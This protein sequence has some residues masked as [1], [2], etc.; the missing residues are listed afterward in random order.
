MCPAAT[1]PGGQVVNGWSPSSRAGRWANSGFVTEI[2]PTQLRDAG[3]D[4][5]DPF[6][7]LD[8]QRR[9][10]RAAYEAGGGSY[11][12][13]AQRLDDFVAGRDSS[14]LPRC[15]YPRG[16]VPARLDTLLGPL[17]P[18]L[19]EALRRIDARMPGFVAPHAVAV[20]LESRT[21]SPIRIERDPETG[22]SPTVAGLYPCG[23]G[24]GHAGGIMSAALDGLR[25]ADHIAR[26][27]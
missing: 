23:E 25:T 9:L 2:G 19:R 10:E 20:A 12:A 18:S 14:E 7:G 5:T 3:L 26:T 8:Y 22:Q 27:L 16:V 17:A 24:P 11:V 13:P 21:S 4:P 1:E 15:S 6:A